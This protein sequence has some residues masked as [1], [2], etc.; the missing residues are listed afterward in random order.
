MKSQL[1]NPRKQCGFTDAYLQ[2]IRQRILK[3]ICLT[4]RTA[5]SG[6]VD[7]TV[8]KKKAAVSVQPSHIV[9]AIE[10]AIDFAIECMKDSVGECE[11]IALREII[12]GIAV[13]I[14][15]ATLGD[16]LEHSVLRNHPVPY[17]RNILPAKVENELDLFVQQLAVEL[18]NS[19]DPVSLAAWVE[20]ELDYGIHP[21][22]DGCGRISKVVSMTVQLRYQL[23]APILPDRAVYYTA[24]EGK[25]LCPDESR[26]EAVLPYFISLP[27]TLVESLQNSSVHDQFTLCYRYWM[28][29]NQD[30]QNDHI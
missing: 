23:L 24:M 2:T 18:N 20:K 11:V 19:R 12:E 26:R 7:A 9:V 1:I 30:I 15:R 13:R 22:A 4:S 17:G 28:K 6:N 3:N 8:S 21:F 10:Q 5:E 16:Q 25:M 14:Q 29:R 27:K